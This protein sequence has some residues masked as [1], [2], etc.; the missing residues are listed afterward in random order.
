MVI[1]VTQ[2]TPDLVKPFIVAISGCFG[3]RDQICG[4]SL[5]QDLQDDLNALH[6]LCVL[7]LL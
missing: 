7:L 1:K 4:E 6:L 3:T 2:P 5:F